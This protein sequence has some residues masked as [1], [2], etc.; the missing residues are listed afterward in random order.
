MEK[1][2]L[3]NATLL[4]DMDHYVDPET[5]EI[6][7]EG[8][9]KAQGA[10]KNKQLATAA[11]IKN[12]QAMLDALSNAIKRL[13]ERKKSAENRI[14][15]VKK[16]LIESMKES[17]TTKL[18]ATDNTYSVTLSIGATTAVVVTNESLIPQEYLVEQPPK[19]DK[20][21]LKKALQNGLFVLGAT[22]ENNDRL[23]I[24]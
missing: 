12:E 19:V 3:F 16:A 22:L 9:M 14:E 24:S 23:L 1:I 20:T 10:L 5:G 11:F 2:S 21:A 18:V 8:F 17:N 4:A 13:T 7:I 15:R 6:D